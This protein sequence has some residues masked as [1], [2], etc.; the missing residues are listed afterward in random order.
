MTLA[1]PNKKVKTPDK[2]MPMLRKYRKFMR[3][4]TNPLK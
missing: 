3:S 1:N 2:I 4:A